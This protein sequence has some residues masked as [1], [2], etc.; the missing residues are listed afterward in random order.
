MTDK[1][2]RYLLPDDIGTLE[3][4]PAVLAHFE[5]HKQLKWS[6]KEAGGQLFACLEDPF[7]IRIV[8]GTG[9]RSTDKRSTYNYLPDRAAEKVEIK[10]RFDRGLHFVGDWHTHKQKLPQP[11]DTDTRSIREL[12]RHSNHDLA[13]FVLIVVG[14][15]PFPNG[16]TVSFHTKSGS[17][18]LRLESHDDLELL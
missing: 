14:Q 9:P 10:E 11:S 7:C 15:A 12:V 18:T 6:A 17:T 8:E 5:T 16:L 13:G 4:L 2:L 3:L 1:P